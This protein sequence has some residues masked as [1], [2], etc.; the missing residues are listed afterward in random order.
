MMLPSNVRIPFSKQAVF[1]VLQVLSTVGDLL[2][3][4][5]NPRPSQGLSAQFLK[6]KFKIKCRLKKKRLMRVV[7]PSK[8]IQLMLYNGMSV[9]V[10][11]TEAMDQEGTTRM[12]GGGKRIRVGVV[13]CKPRKTKDNNLVFRCDCFTRRGGGRR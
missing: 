12:T 5:F 4:H 7:L 9:E 13:K 8:A 2:T 11:V 10:P 1:G 3:A 6:G